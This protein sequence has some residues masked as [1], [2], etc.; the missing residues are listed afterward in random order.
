MRHRHGKRPTPAAAPKSAAVAVIDRSQEAPPPR[1]LVDILRQT[2]SRHPDSAAIDDPSGAITY[3]ELMA[4]VE[5]A[6]SALARAGVR[7]G[8]RV[9]V[10]LPS[11]SRG[12]YVAI[13]AV[14]AARAA[15]V[16]VDADDPRERAD[17]VF[18]EA[19]VV[20]VLTATGY[21]HRAGA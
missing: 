1:T 10:R 12:L 5:S 17:L 8:D 9:G 20:G 16:P 6:A 11:G 15:Y 7:P 4:E 13:L 19:E 18:S 14:L 3:T 21:Q 2:A